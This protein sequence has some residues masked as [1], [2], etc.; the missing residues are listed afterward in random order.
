MEC[1]FLELGAKDPE[2][3][4]CYAVNTFFELFL[5]VLLK[6]SAFRLRTFLLWRVYFSQISKNIELKL[7]RGIRNVKS[8][9]GLDLLNRV[10]SIHS[11]NVW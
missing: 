11:K 7:M 10:E 4:F 6:Y 1:S 8:I 3:L 2:V 5:L 9:G